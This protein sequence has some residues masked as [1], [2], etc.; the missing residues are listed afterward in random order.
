M[1]EI[2]FLPEDTSP[3]SSDWLLIQKSDTNADKKISIENLSSI[4][5]VSPT[6]L[7][8]ADVNGLEAAL[9]N[10]AD[11][12]VIDLLLHPGYVSG[13][14]YTFSPAALSTSNTSVLTTYIYYTYI[15]VPRDCSFSSITVNATA[16]SST[17]KFRIGIYSIQNGLPFQLLVDGGEVSFTSAGAKEKLINF[18][19]SSGWY[20][21]ALALNENS[22]FSVFSS[23]VSLAHVSGNTSLIGLTTPHLG[24]RANFNYSSLPND[25]PITNFAGISIAPVFWLKVS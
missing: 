16:S 9:N 10:K 2:R 21:A 11:N 25:A 17:S 23:T 15:Y 5:Q 24:W 6:D 13:R 4:I 12:Q 8:I 7:Q 14:Y 18:S 1:T 3:Q 20:F 19:L 22:N